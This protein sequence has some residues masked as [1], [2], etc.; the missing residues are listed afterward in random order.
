VDDED[1]PGTQM[2][3]APANTWSELREFDVQGEGYS[4]RVRAGELIEQTG[5]FDLF[6]VSAS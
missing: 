6:R 3:A 2:L 5:R 1:R 4:A